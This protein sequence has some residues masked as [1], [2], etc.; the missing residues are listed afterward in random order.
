MYNIPPIHLN[1]EFSSFSTGS[2]KELRVLNEK[3]NKNLGRK[4]D[5]IYPI[6]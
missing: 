5:K 2:C 3:E 6:K 4:F 1:T